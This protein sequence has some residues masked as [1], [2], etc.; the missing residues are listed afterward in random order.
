MHVVNVEKFIWGEALHTDIK[1]SKRAYMQLTLKN[2][3]VK[4]NLR[5]VFALEQFS[6]S[7]GKRKYQ[8]QFEN[9][10]CFKD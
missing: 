1:L 4:V 5:S 6:W 3:E 10:S 9:E 2:L 7:V 8:V